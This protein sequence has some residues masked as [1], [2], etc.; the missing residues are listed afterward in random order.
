M[1]AKATLYGIPNCDTVKKARRWLDEHGVDYTFH[2]YKKA[3]IDADRLK[4]WSKTF[5][6]DKLLNTRGTTWRKLDDADKQ[7][8][9]EARAITLMQ[10]HHSIIKRPVL[11]AGKH[12]LIGFDEGAWQS[13]L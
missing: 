6:I 4:S 9:T 5:G 3:G 8:M 1:T 12:K 10:T 13:L 2:D 11:I 7:D